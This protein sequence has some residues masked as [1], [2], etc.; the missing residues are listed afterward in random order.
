MIFYKSKSK[1]PYCKIFFDVPKNILTILKEFREVRAEESGE[2]DEDEHFRHDPREDVTDR[3]KAVGEE[4][5]FHGMR[6][7]LRNAGR[8]VRNTLPQ[9]HPFF[10]STP[11]SVPVNNK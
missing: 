7:V 9:G 2:E 10:S 4:W 8:S 5:R 1:N 11:S 3:L 6:Y